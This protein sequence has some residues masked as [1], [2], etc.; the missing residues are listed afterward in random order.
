[1]A[2]GENNTGVIN[3]N[4]ENHVSELTKFSDNAASL[5]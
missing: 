3:Q 1:M 4:I 5:L 2:R